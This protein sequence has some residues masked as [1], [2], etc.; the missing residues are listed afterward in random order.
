[1]FSGIIEEVGTVKE[2]QERPTLGVRH[3]IVRALKVTA[4]TLPGDSISVDGVCLTVVQVSYSS[5]SFDIAGET[6]ARTNFSRLQPGKRVNLERSLKLGDRISGHLVY[7]HIDG[8]VPVISWQGEYLHLG[9]PPHLKPYIKEKG[10]VALN[11]ISL[12]VAGVTP[13]SFSIAI[14]PYTLENTNI[15][16]FGP[17]DFLNFEADPLARYSLGNPDERSGR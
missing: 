2:F 3:L 11:G 1:M 8:V 12:T 5:L 14:I 10:A 15:Q 13:D 6:S 9:I 16:D 7:G 4:D 17:G